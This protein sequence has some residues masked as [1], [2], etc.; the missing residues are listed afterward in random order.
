MYSTSYSLSKISCSSIMVADGSRRTLFLS[1]SARIL[2]RSSSSMRRRSLSS[3][4]SAL[5]FASSSSLRFLSSSW[6][7]SCLA[8][9]AFL[10]S[11]SFALASASSASI[12]FYSASSSSFRLFS[13]SRCI[14]FRKRW[15]GSSD[16]ISCPRAKLTKSEC[17][18]IHFFFCSQFLVTR[19]FS[20]DCRLISFD[21]FAS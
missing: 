11:S 20:F 15:N 8:S 7:A 21:C 16:S 9:S 1:S 6:R 13:R 12:R 3:S 2:C 19:S 5:R 17:F 4:S 10:S 18:L 14:C